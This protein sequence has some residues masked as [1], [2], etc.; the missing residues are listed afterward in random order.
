VALSNVLFERRE[1][2]S[3]AFSLL[4]FLTYYL[5]Q[6]TSAQTTRLSV[7]QLARKA[8]LILRGHVVEIKSEES[9]DRRSIATVIKLSVDEQWKGRKASDVTLRQPGG[10]VGGITQNVSGLPRFSL[11]EDV[12]VFLQRQE[13]GSLATMA[14]RQGKFVVKT[15]PQSKEEFIEDLTG[16]SQRAKDFLAHVRANLK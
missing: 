7:E 5:L 13:D 14:G 12:I 1:I 6:N 9:L 8:D 10:T 15:D 2:V 4:F 3:K 11:G 16:K